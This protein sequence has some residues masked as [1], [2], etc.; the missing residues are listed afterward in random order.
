LL[1]KNETSI[2]PNIVGTGGR[3]CSIK[4][5][6][7]K[8]KGSDSEVIVRNEEKEKGY[9]FRFLFENSL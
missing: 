8:M 1:E 4:V 6:E 2:K 7:K 9:F 3:S 5:K